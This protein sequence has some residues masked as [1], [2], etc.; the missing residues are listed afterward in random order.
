MEQAS[1]AARI[2]RLLQ[3]RISALVDV[4]ET[5]EAIILRGRVDSEHDRHT[6]ERLVARLAPDKPVINRLEVEPA[7]LE[8]AIRELEPDMTAEPVEVDTADLAEDEDELRFAPTDPVVM[9]D[10][11]GRTRVLG[12]FSPTS[13]ESI[14]VEPSAEDEQPGDEALA[15]AIR[16]ELLEDAAT[17]GLQVDVEVRGGV[18]YLR[19]TV[20]GLE[21]VDNVEEV[22]ARV[23]GVREVVDELK[24]AEY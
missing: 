24:I 3:D 11:H 10:P 23:P 6:V 13:M 12:G 2:E 20:P 21:D 5:D 14:E 18:A 19:G 1:R 8:S 7:L 9:T 4:E 17:T 16:R 15:E 22:A